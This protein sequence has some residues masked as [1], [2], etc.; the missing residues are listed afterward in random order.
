MTAEKKLKKLSSQEQ[1][2]LRQAQNI[3]DI[4]K[5][6]GWLDISKFIQESIVWPDPKTYHSREEAIIPYTEAYGAAELAKKIFEFV[7][8]REDV[9]KSITT[10]LDDE[11]DLPNYS[12]GS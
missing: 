2:L 5:S 3:C 7:N 9:I 8:S 1:Q 6:P 10:K 4:V 11:N 12:I